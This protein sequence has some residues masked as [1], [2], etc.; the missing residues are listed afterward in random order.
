LK[1]YHSLYFYKKF[2]ITSFLLLNFTQI[3]AFDKN[4]IEVSTGVSYN[5]TNIL[6]ETPVLNNYTSYGLRFSYLPEMTEEYLDSISFEIDYAKS[7]LKQPTS[8]RKSTDIYHFAVDGKYYFNEQYQRFIP[9][10]MLGGGYFKYDYQA[11]DFSNSFSF[12]IGGGG[13]LRLNSIASLNF[14]VKRE[15]IFN[16]K[17]FQETAVRFNVV[18]GALP[19]NNE[20]IDNDHDGVLDHDDFCLDT[21]LDVAVDVD[22][23]GYLNDKDG[24]GVLDDVDEC[25]KTPITMSVDRKGCPKDSDHDGVRDDKDKCLKTSLGVEVDDLGCP[26]DTDHDGTV[27]TIDR[28]PNTPPNTIVST[29]GCELKEDK[30]SDGIPDDIDQ[31]IDTAKG[32]EVTATGC[33]V[34]KDKDGV[35]DTEDQCKNTPAGTIV[36]IYGCGDFDR[37]KVS[38]FKDKCPNTPLGT[39]VDKY[40]CPFSVRLDIKFQTG[41]SYILR[42]YIKNLDAFID[43]FNKYLKEYK[44]EVQGHTDSIG[45]FNS[46]RIISQ[47]RANAVYN[48]LISHGVSKDRLSYK[49]YGES[50]PIA[51]NETA[52]GR[53]ANRRVQVKLILIEKKKLENDPD[54]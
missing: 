43:Y 21:P 54:K 49:G 9:Y 10:L 25:P 48:Y 53:E 38:N 51:T 52:E 29:N 3:K 46:N 40:G 35:F 30:D 13:I 44:A 16:E 19:K 18:I 20:P 7:D 27:D 41:S 50:Q 23:C 28:C 12:D 31:C 8:T 22:G 47:S 34:D 42:K 4:S 15:I 33:P 32:T 36:D 45:G 24:D 2:I 14:Q 11:I 39:K 1:K 6:S 37:D 26:L 5:F 17:I